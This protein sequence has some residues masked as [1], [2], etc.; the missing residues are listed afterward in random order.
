M[1]KNRMN[2][3]K[4]AVNSSINIF[5][6]PLGAATLPVYT[7]ERHGATLALILSIISVYLLNV[8]PIFPFLLP[9][10]SLTTQQDVEDRM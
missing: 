7:S 9:M 5:F 6:G 3:M 8:N 4:F 2:A 10:C 1:H